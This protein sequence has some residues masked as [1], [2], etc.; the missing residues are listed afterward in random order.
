MTPARDRGGRRQRERGG[1]PSE[2]ER[3]REVGRGEEGK[4]GE[5]D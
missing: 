5:G 2:R 1:A 3:R 4:S